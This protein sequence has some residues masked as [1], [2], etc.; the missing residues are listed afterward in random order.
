MSW[1]ARPHSTLAKQTSPPALILCSCPMNKIRAQSEQYS[2]CTPPA[3]P[4]QEF[5]VTYSRIATCSVAGGVLQGRLERPDQIETK[6]SCR[7]DLLPANLQLSAKRARYKAWNG[8]RCTP[9]QTSVRQT[10]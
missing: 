3:E 4:R 7:R 5:Q 9:F 8:R 1:P 10:P 6:T 2:Y